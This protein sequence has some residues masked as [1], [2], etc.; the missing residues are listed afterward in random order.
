[1]HALFHLA[2][3]PETMEDVYTKEVKVSGLVV[4][5]TAEQ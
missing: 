1:M 4:H 5:S 2:L 3:H